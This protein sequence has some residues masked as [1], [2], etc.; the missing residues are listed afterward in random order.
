MGKPKK[1]RRLIK[2]VKMSKPYALYRLGLLYYEGK[3]V[4]EDVETAVTL[5]EAA[6]IAGYQ[7]AIEWMEDY[8]FD[9]DALTQAY[10]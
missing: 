10:S 1:L 4:A 5:I 7:P 8:K 2:A 9:D 6:G 3:M